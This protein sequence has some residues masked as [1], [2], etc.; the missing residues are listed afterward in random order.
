MKN[1]DTKN[2]FHSDTMWGEE[3]NNLICGISFPK[4]AYNVG[5]P[6]NG[7]L[8]IKNVSGHDLI[9][10]KPL[11]LGRWGLDIQ[12]PAG[13]DYRW[14]GGKYKIK[15]ISQEDFI[16]LKK[17]SVYHD[18]IYT[19]LFLIQHNSKKG[20]AIFSSGEGWQSVLPGKYT[21][22]LFLQ[23]CVDSPPIFQLKSGKAI[24]EVIDE[25]KK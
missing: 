10:L 19:A 17:D 23:M 22:Q 15:P 1:K 14:K 2:L 5:E 9:I 3:K 6:I 11:K 12:G 16:P 7:D 24:I 8:Y 21:I 13:G 20:K 18:T 4:K 25:I